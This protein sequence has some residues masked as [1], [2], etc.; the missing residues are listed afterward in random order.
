MTPSLFSFRRFT[1]LFFLIFPFYTFAY[2]AAVVSARPEA[3]RVGLDVLKKGGNAADSAIAT[4]LAL[5]VVEP[6]NSGLGGGGFFLYYNARTREVTFLDYRETAPQKIT[7]AGITFDDFEKNSALAVGVPGFPAGLEEIYNKFGSVEWESLVAPSIALAEKGIKPIG[8]LAERLQAESK[9]IAEDPIFN[10][11][12]LKPFLTHQKKIHQSALAETLKIYQAE[13]AY[14]FY[15]GEI[16]QKILATLNTRGS[17]ISQND[18]SNYQV[19][20]RKPYRFSE[21]DYEFATAPLPSSGGFALD[22]LLRKA[23]VYKVKDD[24]PFSPEAFQKI[25]QAFKDYFAYRNLA[26]GDVASSVSTHTTHLSIIDSQGNMAAMTNTLNRPFGAALMVPGTG[27]ILNNELLDFS[28]DPQSPNAIGGGKRPLSSMTPTFI[29]KNNTPVLIV[30]TPGGL[31]IPQNLFL[32]LYA[33]LHW[34]AS[35]RNAIALPKFYY[36]PDKNQEAGKVYG[37]I[38]LPELVVKQLSIAKENIV[39]SFGNVQTLEILSPLQTIPWADPRGEG[40]G[41]RLIH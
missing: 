14:P 6:H 32:M 28:R 36:S 39:E 17:I 20:W 37:E 22:F 16:A 8:L 40:K 18:F 38:G 31:S 34:N 2:Q 25:N 27:M 3:T 9:R 35:V 10:E 12:Y 41:M 26:L 33:H 23:I 13:R 19:Y 29:W 11:S 7:D 21:G 30:G 15:E 24:V 1:F 4:A 5:G